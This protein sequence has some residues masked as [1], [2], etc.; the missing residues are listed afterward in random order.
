MKAKVT[1]AHGP[2]SHDASCLAARNGLKGEGV[3]K[4]PAGMCGSHTRSQKWG[5]LLFCVVVS[6]PTK[7]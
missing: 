7:Y 2:C 3:G 1:R 5:Q 4:A 6:F